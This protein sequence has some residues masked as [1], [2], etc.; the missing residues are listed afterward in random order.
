MNNKPVW[1]ILCWRFYYCEGE[2][3]I[4]LLD[5]SI[6]LHIKFQNK[7]FRT[8]QWSLILLMERIVYVSLFTEI[9]DAFHFLK[10][11]IFVIN[12][13]WKLYNIYK[14]NS[15]SEFAITIN[16]AIQENSLQWSFICKNINRKKHKVVILMY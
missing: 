1:K 6:I 4:L 2:K 3:E 8:T 16:L 10:P 9:S 15:N 12:W 13:S 11:C 14:I 5:S 7:E